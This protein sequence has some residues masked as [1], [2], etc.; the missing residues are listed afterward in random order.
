MYSYS[1]R[2]ALASCRQESGAAVQYALVPRQRRPRHDLRQQH[3]NNW[4][5]LGKNGT[6]KG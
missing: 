4:F 2:R 1:Y 5:V 3:I 6:V